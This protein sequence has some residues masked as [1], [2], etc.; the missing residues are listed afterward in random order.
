MRND[1]PSMLEDS[2]NITH[3]DVPNSKTSRFER[4]TAPLPA[5]RGGSAA[6]LLSTPKKFSTNS[7][8]QIS[9]CNRKHKTRRPIHLHTG[10]DRFNHNQS[11]SITEELTLPTFNL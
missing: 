7:H 2:S 8:N 6:L 5:D 3:K 1:F 9:S 4:V 10:K 11:P